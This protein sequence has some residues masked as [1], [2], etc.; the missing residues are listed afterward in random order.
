MPTLRHSC[1]LC[2]ASAKEVRRTLPDDGISGYAFDCRYCSRF[3]LTPTAK[4]DLKATPRA[5]PILA[6][7]ARNSAL[8]QN[9]R[10]L[11]G[12]RTVAAA[13]ARAESGEGAGDDVPLPVNRSDRPI[14]DRLPTQTSC[15][16]KKG[17]V[18]ADPTERNTS[19]G[20]TPILTRRGCRPSRA[21]PLGP[22]SR[23][24]R[25]TSSA[26]LASRSRSTDTLPPPKCE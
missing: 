22:F 24:W 16:L 12:S 9:P 1:P 23:S 11:I 21:R 5:R 3:L 17:L 13:L 14:G 19:P 2:G 25:R 7:W 15:N 6:Q 8:A 4:M 26:H 10:F 18:S 20:G